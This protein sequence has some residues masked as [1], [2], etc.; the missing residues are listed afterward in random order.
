MFTPVHAASLRRQI[1]KLRTAAADDDVATEDYL[2]LVA[3]LLDDLDTQLAKVRDLPDPAIN[4][5]DRRPEW[6]TRD[7]TV[8][9]DGPIIRLWTG[10]GG[11]VRLTDTDVDDLV[12]AL[13]AAKLRA[14]EHP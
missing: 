11:E 3:D 8:D 10:E 7:T 5:A 2:D 6:S 13:T 12:L 4:P 1:E 14:A 9:V